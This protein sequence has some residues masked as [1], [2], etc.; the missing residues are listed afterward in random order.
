MFHLPLPQC[1]SRLV[2]PERAKPQLRRA[3]ELRRHLA[4][5]ERIVGQEVRGT[6]L[7]VHLRRQSPLPPYV[8]DFD[9]PQ[10]RLVVEIGGSPHRQQQGHNQLRDACFAGCGIH[11]LRVANHAVRDDL[12]AVIYLRCNALR[13]LP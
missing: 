6:R 13:H 3:A 8:V 2:W 7:G 1:L 5:E 12:P 11:L 9:C 10:V 4:P